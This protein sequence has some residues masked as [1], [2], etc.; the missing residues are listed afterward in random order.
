[1]DNHDRV[2]QRIR[3]N[4]CEDQA[5]IDCASNTNL[6]K[7][8][9]EIVELAKEHQ[10]L[11]KDAKNANKVAILLQFAHTI[12]TV[13]EKFLNIKIGRV[14]TQMLIAALD[15]AATA[16]GAEADRLIGEMDAAAK[17]LRAIEKK[18]RKYSWNLSLIKA[19]SDK[20]RSIFIEK[21]CNNP[22][23]IYCDPRDPCK[24]IR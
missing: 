4:V 5:K 18:Y 22:P 12:A 23:Y 20:A 24:R 16:A 3:D 8:A 19:R 1:M 10:K 14:T 11:V 9:S 21:G 15:A 13:G 17:Q 6:K 7:L 2:C